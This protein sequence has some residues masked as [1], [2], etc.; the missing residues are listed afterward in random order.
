[1]RPLS[2]LA[3]PLIALLQMSAPGH[4][5]VPPQLPEID[6]TAPATVQASATNVDI[7]T[8]SWCA[9]SV[10]DSFACKKN[11]NLVTLSFN[12]ITTNWPH[13][14]HLDKTRNVNLTPLNLVAG[15]VLVWESTV[16]A[17][18]GPFKNRRITIGRTTTVQ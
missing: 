7:V 18:A 5:G 14:N 17:T 16:W 1:M 15:D 9:Y 4:V 6:E 12:S 8:T 10:A 2:L 11:G 3:L 13:A